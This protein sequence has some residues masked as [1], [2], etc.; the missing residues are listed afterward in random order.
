MLF[1]S[2]SSGLLSPHA[3]NTIFPSISWSPSNLGQMLPVQ[4][5]PLKPQ[6]KKPENRVPHHCIHSSSL[7]YCLYCTWYILF[8]SLLS[9]LF[10]YNITVTKAL[11]FPLVYLLPHSLI[12]CL[13][14]TSHSTERHGMNE[15][16]CGGRCE[17]S[18]PQP[19]CRGAH[20]SPGSRYTNQMLHYDTS[21]KA[22]KDRI[23]C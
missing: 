12:H 8:I 6:N 18:R 5:G 4:W 17:S 3:W 21:N 23:K 7:F 13:A 19:R 16:Y 15:Y 10:H 14:S 2:T 20:I 1:L 9:I 11:I 22:K